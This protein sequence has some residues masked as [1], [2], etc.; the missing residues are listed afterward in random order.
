MLFLKENNVDLTDVKI[1][2]GLLGQEA[3]TSLGSFA[4]NASSIASSIKYHE[5]FTPLFSPENFEL[6]QAFFATAQSVRDALIIN[7]NPTYD[8]YEKLNEVQIKSNISRFSGFVWHDN[9]VIIN[10]CEPPP[11]RV[12]GKRVVEGCGIEPME[13]MGLY[14]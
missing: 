12:M 5:E 8:Y 10:H 6:P 3:S 13:A 7:W 4:P 2:G 11:E 14:T 9:E 1:T